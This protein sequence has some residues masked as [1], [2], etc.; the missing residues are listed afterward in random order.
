MNLIFGASQC[1][2]TNYVRV[3]LLFL[4]RMEKRKRG[5]HNNRQYLCGQQVGGDSFSKG[6]TLAPIVLAMRSK[7]M[8]RILLSL[9]VLE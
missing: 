7:N 1:L 6:S 5:T 9:S 4:R 3:D 8:P 2:R